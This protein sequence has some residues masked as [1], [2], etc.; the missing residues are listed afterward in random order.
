MTLDFN[1]PPKTAL[2]ATTA[3]PAGH[4][5]LRKADYSSR[6]WVQT[7]DGKKVSKKTRDAAS[8]FVSHAEEQNTFCARVLF[9]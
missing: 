5:L 6:V 2:N 8:V 3:H 7:L 1:L 9:Q 4:M